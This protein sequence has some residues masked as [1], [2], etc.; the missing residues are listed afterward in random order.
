[1]R[2]QTSI[3]VVVV[4]AALLS[5][6][7]P[8]QAIYIETP[9]QLDIGDGKAEV[10]DDLELP[11]MPY[12]D[13]A[14]AREDWAGKEVRIG[15]SYDK[16]EN[17]ETDPDAPASNEGVEEGTIGTVTLDDQA[18]GTLTWKVP[19]ELDGFNVNLFITSLDGEGLAFAYLAV[20]DA[21]ELVRIMSG[22]GGEPEHRLGTEDVHHDG[23]SE[24]AQE[25]SGL[26]FVGL[27]AGVAA[28]L[29]GFALRRR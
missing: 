21:P 27:V 17:R 6:M 9:L 12:P 3:I 7:S 24:A 11:I 4:A 16:N 23:D 5:M 26:A 10:G 20:G 19:G 2:N 14:S 15:Y 8:A 18:K 28:A 29:A 25:A 1:M 13:N 22:P